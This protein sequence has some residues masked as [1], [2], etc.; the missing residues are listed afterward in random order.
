MQPRKEDF[1][2]LSNYYLGYWCPCSHLG[3]EGQWSWQGWPFGISS[4]GYSCT[5]TEPSNPTSLKH[6]CSLHTPTALLE[7]R[8]SLITSQHNM[9]QSRTH[10]WHPEFTE[11]STPSNQRK[12][13]WKL[14]RLQQTHCVLCTFQPHRASCPAL[15][16]ALHT[17]WEWIHDTFTHFFTLYV[18]GTNSHPEYFE[19]PFS[20]VFKHWTLG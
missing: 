5:G 16:S 6:C 12:K 11:P 9:G 10:L 3:A 13:T 18:D 4:W 7:A 19:A 8:L 17:P 14:I 2:W 15:L 20:S 1:L